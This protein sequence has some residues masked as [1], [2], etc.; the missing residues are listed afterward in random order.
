MRA[1]AARLG[2]DRTRALVGVWQ[3]FWTSRLAIWLVGLY[4][5]LKTGFYPGIVSPPEIAPFGGLGNLLA[6]PFAR[7]DSY[8]FLHIAAVGYHHVGNPAFFPLYPLLVAALGWV[9]G[10]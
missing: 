7:W 5:I 3:A 1:L 8:W 4:A 6:G 10:S 2:P 9:L